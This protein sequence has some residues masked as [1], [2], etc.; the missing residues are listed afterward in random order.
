MMNERIEWLIS[1]RSCRNFADDK[2]ENEKLDQIAR[3]ACN[4]PTARNRQLWQFTIVTD[5]NVLKKLCTVIEK[6][7]DREGYSFYGAPV[8]ILCSNDREHRFGREDCA[9]AMHNIYLAAHALELGCVWINQ[10]TDICDCE[11][12]RNILRPLDV[13]DNHVVYGCAAIGYAKGA[14]AQKIVSYPI[15]WH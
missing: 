14:P 10:L 1:R 3:A 6:E 8:L 5:T 12:I 4:A 15:V 9:C 11:D 13:P 2:V 7:L